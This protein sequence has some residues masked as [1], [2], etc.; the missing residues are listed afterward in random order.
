VLHGLAFAP[1]L[2]LNIRIE[3]AEI[4]LTLQVWP[5]IELHDYINLCI[6]SLY[7][8]YIYIMLYNATTGMCFTAWRSLRCLGSTFGLKGL[9]SSSLYRCVC[10]NK[11]QYTICS[12]HMVFYI[13][14]PFA[15]AQCSD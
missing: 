4:K 1:L 7:S 9:Q 8:L 3:G 13:L 6:Y 11:D 14:C 12:I 5:V 2:G 15:W 10:S